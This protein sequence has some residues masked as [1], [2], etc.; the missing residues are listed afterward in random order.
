VRRERC[1]RGSAAFFAAAFY[2]RVSYR[3]RFTVMMSPAGTSP[4]LCRSRNTRHVC[5]SRNTR[6]VLVTVLH[7]LLRNRTVAGTA[8]CL[9]SVRSA[10]ALRSPVFSVLRSFSRL[11]WSR[12]FSPLVGVV[13]ALRLLALVATLLLALLAANARSGSRLIA[14]SEDQIA[15]R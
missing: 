3:T 15:S 12:L 11:T 6:H 7:Q 10:I 9:P 13:F 14:L 8:V 4:R 5:R 1:L 2:G